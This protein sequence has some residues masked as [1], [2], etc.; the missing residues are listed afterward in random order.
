MNATHAFDRIN[1]RVQNATLAHNLY[2]IAQQF[3]R[4]TNRDLCIEHGRNCKGY[5]IRL[6]TDTKNNGSWTFEMDG[7]GDSNGNVLYAIIRNG[8]VFTVM[9][10]REAQPATIKA[11]RVSHI[12]KVSVK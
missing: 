7:S 11:M 8:N 10:R 12:G 2:T 1:A 9:W 4:R 5:A 6:Y 3:A